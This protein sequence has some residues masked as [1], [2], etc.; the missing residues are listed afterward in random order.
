MPKATTNKRATIG[1]IKTNNTNKARK[2]G[3]LSKR[4]SLK[5]RK[6]QFFVFVLVVAILGGGYYTYKSYAAG[7]SI[8]SASVANGS[9]VCASGP[10]SYV[11]DTAKNNNYVIKLSKGGSIRATNNV[12]LSPGVYQTCIVARGTAYVNLFP[13]TNSSNLQLTSVGLN[14]KGYQKV[15]NHFFNSFGSTNSMLGFYLGGSDVWISMIT[16]DRIGDLPF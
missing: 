8:A 7:T 4:F 16:V 10:C 6:T 2:K 13:N 15:C 1:R 12:R 11:R 14:T 3:L 9:L 5:S